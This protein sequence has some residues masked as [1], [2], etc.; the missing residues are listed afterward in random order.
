MDFSYTNRGVYKRR[1][2]VIYIYIYKFLIN[3]WMG[4]V[5]GRV[6]GYVIGAVLII[7]ASRFHSK[8]VVSLKQI[9]S[10]SRV[11]SSWGPFIRPISADMGN[12]NQYTFTI[13]EYKQV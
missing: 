7:L 8:H 6:W 2:K 12:T 5:R 13:I 11:L 10:G 4:S 3:Q 9:D 1:C